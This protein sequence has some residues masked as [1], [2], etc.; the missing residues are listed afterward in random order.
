MCAPCAQPPPP[1]LFL[2]RVWLFKYLKVGLEEL[3]SLQTRAPRAHSTSLSRLLYTTGTYSNIWPQE[4]E[5]REEVKLC[6]PSSSTAS[7]SRPLCW[8]SSFPGSSALGRDQKNIVTQ[9]IEVKPP[10]LVV[11]EELTDS[12]FMHWCLINSCSKNDLKRQWHTER[13][14][15]S[16]TPQTWSWVQTLPKLM[17]KKQNLRI[18][19]LILSWIIFCR[20]CQSKISGESEMCSIDTNKTVSL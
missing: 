14:H 11:I 3:K 2:I 1:P 18:F 15:S 10:L 17:F 13:I 16:P 4:P 9:E 20:T 7:V 19:C 5:L 8:E 6:S 12:T